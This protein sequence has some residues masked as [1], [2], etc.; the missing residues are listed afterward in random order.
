MKKLTVFSLAASACIASLF[1]LARAQEPDAA[2][3]IGTSSL[4]NAR[5]I[6][7]ATLMYAQDYDEM[8]PYGK[9]TAVIKP[10]VFPYIKN[11]QLFVDPV[12]GKDFMYN[13]GMSAMAQSRLHS[14]VTTVLYHSPKAHTD[15]KFTVAYADGHCK[16][17]PKM[18][19]LKVAADPL[20]GKKPPVK[21]AKPTKK[22]KG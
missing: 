18:P 5:Q 2:Q 16:R 17:E 4:S 6:A 21:A 15:G 12:S 3:A 7:T 1:G 10:K 14:P 8:F 11:N 19:S 22:K 20:P 13:P 9:T